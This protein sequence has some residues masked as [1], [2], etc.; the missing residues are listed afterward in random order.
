ME[1]GHLSCTVE[2]LH[3]FWLDAHGFLQ[4]LYI[5]E[6]STL[7]IQTRKLTT[8]DSDSLSDTTIYFPS[9]AD[10]FLIAISDVCSS[11]A[12]EPLEHIA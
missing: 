10:A 2:E 12:G 3:G 9:P 4:P 7:S 1:P 11:F 5:R 6:P 8:S